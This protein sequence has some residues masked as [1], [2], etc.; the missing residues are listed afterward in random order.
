MLAGGRRARVLALGAAARRAARGLDGDE[1][2]RLAG[3]AAPALA[4]ISSTLAARL[5]AT[6]ARP[7]A[8][9]P[10]TARFA[11]LAAVAGFWRGRPTGRRF[12]SH[13]R[14]CTGPTWRRCCCWRT[15][16]ASSR[17]T[18]SSWYQVAI[19]ATDSAL[20]AVQTASFTVLAP[21]RAKARK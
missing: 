12:C 17:T 7:G 13:S 8:Q 3:D 21:K 2:Q 4:T 18:R 9:D 10:A 1:L 5:P 20:S 11:L 19:T 6:E 14:T 15:S 16:A